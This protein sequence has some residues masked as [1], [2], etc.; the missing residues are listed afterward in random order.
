MERKSETNRNLTRVNNLTLISLP[1]AF[2]RH[3][4]SNNLN[5]FREITRKIQVT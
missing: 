4:L 2:M 5:R 1:R 3:V